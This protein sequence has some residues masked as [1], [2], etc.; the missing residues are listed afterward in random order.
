MK[1]Q[2]RDQLIS[3]LG[4][5]EQT[6]GELAERFD[7]HRTTLQRWLG[8]LMADG[9]VQRT[10]WGRYRLKGSAL[11]LNDSGHRVLEVVAALQPDAHLTGFDV[12]ASYAHQFLVE[13][14]HLVYAE[15]AVVDTA[16]F[17]LAAAGF[18]VV[19]ATGRSKP[20]VTAAPA[21]TVVLRTQP[22]AEQ[23]GV[24]GPVASREKAWV[25][26][27]REASRGQLPFDFVELGRVLRVLLDGGA[28]RR[29]LRNYARRM[30]YLERVDAAMTDSE[31]A[32]DH[33]AQVATLRAGFW[34]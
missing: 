7:V 13:Y 31:P 32:D 23:Y 28:D 3:A 18:V 9:S 26:T 33:D 27:L 2:R 8:E 10:G 6:P 20:A 1:T 22:N 30:G 34:S 14:P 16:A 17:E 25:D 11:Q 19:A 24:H 4:A 15:P 12:L 29:K 5:G 21:Q